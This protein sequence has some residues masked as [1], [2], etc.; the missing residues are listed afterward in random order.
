MG[1]TF[2]GYKLT[3]FQVMQINNPTGS[4]LLQTAMEDDAE[5]L[6]GYFEV[7]SNV[8][9]TR[10]EDSSSRKFLGEKWPC[11]LVLDDGF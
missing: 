6:L 7:Q 10:E 2:E 8:S 5:L 3:G 9:V 11:H 4:L 1:Q